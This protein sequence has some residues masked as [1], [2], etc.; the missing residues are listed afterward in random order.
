MTNDQT[1]LVYE[2]QELFDGAVETLNGK[3]MYWP[4]Q[5]NT[6]SEAR[7]LLR[8]SARLYEVPCPKSLGRSSKAHPGAGS[9]QSGVLWLPRS[10]RATEIILHEFAHYI[11]MGET[12]GGDNGASHGPHFVTIVT[13]LWHAFG[14]WEKNYA[15]MQA[16]ALGIKYARESDVYAPLTRRWEAGLEYL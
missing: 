9:C 14:L 13:D 15:R 7:K 6:L 11:E 2:W 3:R 10:A 16:K 1:A 5:L 8:A 4:E 12:S